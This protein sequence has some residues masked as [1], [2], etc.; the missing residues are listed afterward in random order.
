MGGIPAATTRAPSSYLRLPAQRHP[1]CVKHLYSSRVA[2]PSSSKHS[3][4]QDSCTHNNPTMP[5][6]KLLPSQRQR[7][8]EACN[9]CREAKRRCS[10]TTPC[11]H[12]LRRGMAS[13]CTMTCRPRGS[14]GAAAA[15]AAAARSEGSD[16]GAASG[17][18]RRNTESAMSD[19]VFMLNDGQRHSSSAVSAGAMDTSGDPTTRE[20]FRP[21]SPSESRPEHESTPT[22]TSQTQNALSNPDLATMS[23]HPRMLL[24]R[25]GE[26]GEPMSR[27][28]SSTRPT[29]LTIS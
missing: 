1:Y 4:S 15:A 3:S 12:C 2:D 9:L 24:N 27:R 5:R 28:R 25:R 10:G 7:A 8:A 23:P 29:Q 14:R 17:S 22:D 6:P 21:I 11:A 19:P 16:S 18:A 20:M 13:S 26:R